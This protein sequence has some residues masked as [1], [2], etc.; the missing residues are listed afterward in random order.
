MIRTIVRA[1]FLLI[2]CAGVIS[3]GTDTRSLIEGKVVDGLADKAFNSS[4]NDSDN[5]TSDSGNK[6]SQKKFSGS[7][8]GDGH[9]I[10]SDI[11]FIS[12]EPFKGS[13]WIYVKTAKTVTPASAKTKNEGLYMTTSD[14]DEI[15]T[16]YF[17]K[18]R[19]ASEKELKT[20]LIVIAFERSEDD[21]YVSPE[22]KSQAI[23]DNWFM[24]KITDMSDRHKG[25]V[26]VSGGYKISLE[27]I[28]IAV[29]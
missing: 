5:K 3:C 12:K 13:G 4:S 8:T 15:W 7:S 27:N 24:A 14:G 19:I 18:T 20:G 23:S 9:Y 6:K 1:S 16:K 11:I 26:T 22:N 17:W 25:Y 10:D 21:V 2:I 29:K 28:R